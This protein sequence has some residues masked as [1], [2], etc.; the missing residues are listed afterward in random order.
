MLD[1]YD[2]QKDIWLCHSFGGNCYNFTSFQPA[3]NVLKE[4]QTFLEAN[5]AEIITIFIEDYV[6]TTQGLTK[7]FDAAGLRKYWFPVSRM[8][9]KG[10]DWPLISD[11]ISQN[12]RLLVFTSS[13][14]KEASEGIAYEWRYVV[15]N[16][17]GDDGMKSGGCPSR[18]D[19]S[20]MDSA[21]Q[22]LVLMNHFPDTPT[23]SE[24][25]RDNSAPLVNM[26]N[27]CHNSSSNQ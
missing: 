26:L 21:S 25:C 16:Q 7:V 23:P 20:R 17:Y 27:T 14:S 1:M 18:A 2:F 22:S 11:M 4:I 9:K 13:S 8:P 19:S 12:Q 24:A 5:P 3:I 6:K 10:E 15:K